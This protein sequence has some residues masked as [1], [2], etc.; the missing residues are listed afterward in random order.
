MNYFHPNL[1][2]NTREQRNEVRP[3]HADQTL[4]LPEIYCFCNGGSPGWYN[5]TALSEDGEFLAGHCCS[6]EAY[7]P[8]DMGV[9]STWKHEHYIARYPDGYVLIWVPGKPTN[10]P[11]IAA[12]HAKHVAAGELGTAWQQARK[13]AEAANG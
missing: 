2:D 12:A 1:G 3:A 7:G 9:T 10:D 6:S 13:E 5:M 8:G 4:R 11:R